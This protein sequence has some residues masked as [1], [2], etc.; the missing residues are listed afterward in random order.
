MREARRC[1]AQLGT[2]R[3]MIREH[4]AVVIGAGAA[5]AATAALLAR[6]GWSVAVVER[7]AFPRRKVCGEC[8][9]APNLPLLDELGVG[10]ELAAVAGPPLERDALYAAD[11][12]LETA[13]PAAHDPRHRYGRA[14]AR[15][16]LD[17]ALA[18]R[19]AALGAELWQPWTVTALAG[20]P[21]AYAI[22]LETRGGERAALRARVLI[23][24]HGSWERAPLATGGRAR[25]T[26]GDLLAFK[27]TFAGADLAPGVLPVLALPGGYGGMVVGARGELTVACCVRRDRLARCRAALSGAT[28]GEAVEQWLARS[29]R[30][31]RRA[32]R[33]ARRN[34]RWLAAGPIRPGFR[35][36]WSAPRGFAVGNAAGEAHPLLGE[37]IGMALQGAWLLAAA[38]EAEPAA[39]GDGAP[40]VHAR[41][42]RDYA[43]RWRAQLASRVRFASLCAALAMRPRMSQ[44]LLPLLRRRP[45]ALALCARVGGKVRALDRGRGSF[46]FES[47]EGPR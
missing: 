45:E 28:A 26:A 6:A 10:A 3:A 14:I 39:R 32:L 17:T 20:G 42:A 23:D 4:D 13:L 35:P 30:G 11:V 40:E 8:V 37:G 21:G 43:A 16:D 25:R 5:G 36:L 2:A 46:S 38:L 44:A 47:C 29:C 24:A 9:A 31:A 41:I 7:R 15:E 1:A 19:A 33:H 18:R 27:A 12:L 34:G 22:A